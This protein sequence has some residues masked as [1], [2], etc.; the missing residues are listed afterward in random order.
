MGAGA[1]PAGAG[2][3]DGDPAGA[4][5]PAVDADDEVSASRDPVDWDPLDRG[6]VDRGSVD[7]D[8]VD[9]DSVDRDSVD[10]DS[11]SRP[12]ATGTSAGGG[13]AGG[14][15]A[16]GGGPASGEAKPGLPSGSAGATGGAA[17]A[18]GV[19]SLSAVATTTP[20]VSLV[21]SSAVSSEISSGADASRDPTDSAGSGRAA[22]CGRTDAGDAG[23]AGLATGSR[24]TTNR[25][26]TV[27]GGRA[28]AGGLP[29][30][31]TSSRRVGTGETAGSAA[32]TSLICRCSACAP[33]DGRD[34]RTGSD[35]CNRSGLSSGEGTGAGGRSPVTADS[36]TTGSAGPGKPPVGLGRPAGWRTP[37]MTPDGASA[38][39]RWRSGARRDGSC[40][41]P[42][43][44]RK[45][46]G[47][48]TKSGRS[49]SLGS[50]GA[51]RQ[52]SARA[53]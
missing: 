31:A 5:C 45:A 13:P 21:V 14:G 1:G 10:R 7:R 6:S 22:G 39:T 8:S 2:P 18:V 25:R 32:E 19:T 30:R 16:T 3:A 34:S 33:W 28:A 29:D 20:A 46:A 41:L 49:I 38:L 35:R 36:F 24:R 40:Q 52:D 4:D 42:S 43:P 26:A 11:V 50:A 53:G 23:D 9:R 17:D 27:S 44:A 48:A 51:D 15:P 47:S 12:P 37:W